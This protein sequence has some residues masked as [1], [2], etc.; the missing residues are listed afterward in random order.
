M[1][2]AP[3]SGNGLSNQAIHLGFLRTACGGRT[4]PADPESPASVWILTGT[5]SRALEVWQSA[6]LGAGLEDLVLDT[7][8]TQSH[9]VDSYLGRQRSE[10]MPVS[11]GQ[12]Q[13]STCL[14]L[15][16]GGGDRWHMCVKCV[17]MLSLHEKHG[18]SILHGD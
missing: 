16:V 17:H 18:N 5:G 9:G 13:A 1:S 10:L 8:P 14:G 11:H 6:G 2:G 3:T 7:S 4:S 15:A 12:G